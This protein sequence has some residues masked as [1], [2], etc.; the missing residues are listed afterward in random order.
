MKIDIGLCV[1]DDYRRGRG[2]RIRGEEMLQEDT[3]CLIYMVQEGLT[4]NC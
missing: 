1:L 3:E 2:L 4:D